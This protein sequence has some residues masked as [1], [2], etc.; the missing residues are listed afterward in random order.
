MVQ[1]LGL[2]ASTA[3][4]TGSTPVHGARI[5]QAAWRG[6]KKKVKCPAQQCKIKMVCRLW[7]SVKGEATFVGVLRFGGFL[8]T[9]CDV[10]SKKGT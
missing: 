8:L 9:K 6:Q 2:H 3:G 10:T 5:P 1:W 7:I 4:G